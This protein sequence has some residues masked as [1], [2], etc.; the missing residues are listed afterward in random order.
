MT[1]TTQVGQDLVLDTNEL[2]CGLDVGK[3]GTKVVV[4]GDKGLKIG[5][6]LFLLLRNGLE[7]HLGNPGVRIGDRCKSYVG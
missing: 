4:T 6:D 1:A 7:E 2:L 3:H 5:T